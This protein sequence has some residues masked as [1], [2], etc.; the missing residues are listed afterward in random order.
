MDGERIGGDSERSLAE[1]GPAAGLVGLSAFWA[2]SC[3]HRVRVRIRLQRLG[4]LLL[5]G[6]SS[7]RCFSGSDG[8]GVGTG[9]ATTGDTYC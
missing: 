5:G 9:Y 6:S 7:R 2:S 8:G 1:R 4:L 3:S